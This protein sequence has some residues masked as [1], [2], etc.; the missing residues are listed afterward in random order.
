MTSTHPRPSP[1]FTGI[2]FALT[3]TRWLLPAE[4]T[5][6]GDTLW[7]ALLW[8]LLAGAY[9]IWRCSHARRW[10][11]DGA[12]LAAALLIGGQVVSGGAVLAGEGN[13]RA[14][15]N[16]IWEWLSL[17]LLWILWRDLLQ[18]S[19]LRAALT[20]VMLATAV[21][22]S[23]WGLWQYVEWYPRMQRQYGPLFD[24]LR[25][26]EANGGNATALLKQLHEA[27]IPT[28][29]GSR[30]LFENRLRSS[31][32]P[33][34]PFALANTFGGLLAAWLVLGCSVLLGKKPKGRPPHPN[35]LPRGGGEGTGA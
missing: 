21:A 12:D 5:A 18:S 25:R 22:L 32:E 3:V 1:I 15:L 16:L 34:G 8:F 29:R 27:G 17:G 23:L 7:I 4:A 28:E 11:F 35:P 24:E 26:V 20:T 10:R 9:G 30:D 6:E 31:H 33:F 2:A 14:A 19:R 13:H